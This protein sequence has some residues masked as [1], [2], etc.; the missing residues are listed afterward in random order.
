M[1][2][3]MKHIKK[4]STAVRNEPKPSKNDGHRTKRD[5]TNRHMASKE[6]VTRSAGKLMRE[7]ATA[8]KWLAD[9]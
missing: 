7:H 9:K 6:S 3:L 5:S 1:E 8:L 2:T 4:D